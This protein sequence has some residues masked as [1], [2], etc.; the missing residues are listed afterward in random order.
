MMED[1]AKTAAL[2]NAETEKIGAEEFSTIFNQLAAPELYEVYS[3][4][5]PEEREAYFEEFRKF[6]AA[7]RDEGLSASAASP[8]MVAAWIISQREIDGSMANAAFRAEALKFIYGELDAH[9]EAALMICKSRAARKSRAAIDGAA[10][11]SPII[12]RHAIADEGNRNNKL[13][14]K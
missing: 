8:A 9:I 10:S 12:V 2:Y 14:W 4:V 13:D 11:P 3:R 5:S 6:A 7:C 1:T